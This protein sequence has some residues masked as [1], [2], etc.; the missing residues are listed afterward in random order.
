MTTATPI[1]SA[2]PNTPVTSN[3]PNTPKPPASHT[4][5]A[6]VV[7]TEA[8]IVTAGAVGKNVEH[9]ALAAAGGIAALFLAL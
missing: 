4:T 2:A 9:G 7:T 3:P 5:I 6:T 1:T 8:P